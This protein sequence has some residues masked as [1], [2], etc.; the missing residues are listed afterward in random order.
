MY[1]DVD[2]SSHPA[3]IALRE[4]DD[5]KA[6]KVVRRGEGDLA[7]AL[8]AVGRVGDEDH[9]FLLPDAVRALAGARGGDAGWLEGFAAMLDYAGQ[10]GWVADD[11]AVRAHVERA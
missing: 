9:V 4:P 5:F 2:L 3:A 1:L 11:G 7:A 8:G 6:F 10:H